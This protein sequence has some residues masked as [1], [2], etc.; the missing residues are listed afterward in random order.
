MTPTLAFRKRKKTAGVIIH[1]TH[2]PPSTANLPQYLAVKG[3]QMGLLEVGYHFVIMRDGSTFSARPIDCIGTHTR[4]LDWGYLGVALVGGRH[5]F[6]PLCA[7]G[8]CQGFVPECPKDDPAD[9]FTP[10]QGRALRTL[11][12]L[13]IRPLYGDIPVLGHSEARERHPT[14]CPACDMKELRTWIATA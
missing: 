3:R 2:T 4:G 14:L 9:N 7:S 13:T 6:C 10:E 11:L 5:D 8:D 1:D 12:T